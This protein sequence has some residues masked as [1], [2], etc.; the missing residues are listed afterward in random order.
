MGSSNGRGNKPLIPFRQW[1]AVEYGLHV[2]RKNG[3]PRLSGIACP[4]VYIMGTE[5][6]EC[7]ANL[8]DTPILVPCEE[9]HRR[10]MVCGVCGMG[11]CRRLAQE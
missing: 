7:G 2:E 5:V 11:Q 6:R 10:V 8:W 4:E 9:G 3:Y 1:Q